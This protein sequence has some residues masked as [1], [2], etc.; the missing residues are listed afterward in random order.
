M[1][2]TAHQKLSYE[3]AK[4]LFEAED[5]V[6]TP[7]ESKYK[8]R[9]ILEE[10]RDDI[11]KLRENNETDE[12][13][14]FIEATLEY[15]LA[16]NYLYTEESSSGKEKLKRVLQLIDEK[17]YLKPKIV[18]IIIATLNEFGVLWSKRF[19]DIEKA[20]EYLA[21]SEKL[22][23]QYK[24]EV[25][26]SPLT[27]HN[28]FIEATDCERKHSFE[29]L[30][31]HT[32]F[33]IAQAL[34][35]LN[36]FEESANYCMMTLKRQINTETYDPLQW[37]INCAALSQ[38]FIGEDKFWE[39]RHCLSCATYVIDEA[40]SKC[41]DDN[42]SD[43][44]EKKA[45]IYRCWLKYCLALFDISKCKVANSDGD[46]EHS[47]VLLAIEEDKN[48]KEEYKPEFERFP[49]EVTHIEDGVTYKPVYTFEK[50]RDLFAKGKEFA[51]FSMKQFV[52]DGF[53]TDHIEINQDLSRMYQYIAFYE[54]SEAVK[55]RMHKRRVDI[56]EKML[57]GLNPQHYL[58]FCRQLQFELAEV[59]SE[60]MD[61]KR[62]IAYKSNT[63]QNFQVIKKI[64]RYCQ[65][66][67]V[68]I[69]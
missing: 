43:L 30:Y 4:G 23:K 37:S 58:A 52:L 32:L 5:P 34:K 7:F 61:L 16:I 15:Q 57:D 3:K 51:D 62:Q 46:L 13:L 1:A 48:L 9:K 31:T 42:L 69:N 53:V 2:L 6:E 26:E 56:L 27:V 33:F 36:K 35:T 21:S 47:L 49:I 10:L 68:Y 12:E 19:E 44:K 66:G 22:Y 14:L 28:Q 20:Y 17:H 50:A 65:L 41:T 25:D 59:Y 24:E 11:H 67:L 40:L 64:N 18:C 45:D 29:N 55:C 54:E 38:F 39:A 8:S 63:R 60:M